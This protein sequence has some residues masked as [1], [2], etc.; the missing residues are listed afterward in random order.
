MGILLLKFKK[1][2]IYT[3]KNFF[4]IGWVYVGLYFKI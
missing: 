4:S 2:G 3:I 1:M